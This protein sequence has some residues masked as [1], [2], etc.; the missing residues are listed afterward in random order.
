MAVER[1]IKVPIP[2]GTTGEIEVEIPAEFVHP[3]EPAFK[4][5]F[6]PAAD[7]QAELTR[8][9]ANVTKGLIKRDE[10]IEDPEFLGAI[11]TKKRDELLKIMKIEPGAGAPDIKA[12]R[13]EL[14]V[15]VRKEFVTPLEARVAEQDS[16]IGD[17]KVAGLR[18][19]VALAALELNMEPENQ[20]LVEMFVQ[21]HAAYDPKARRH[22]IK[23]MNGEEGFEYSTDPKRGGNTHMGVAEF[24]A[25]LKKGGEKKTWFRDGTQPGAG[26]QAGDPNAEAM[27]LERFQKL[28]STERTK[29]YQTNAAKY[30]EFMAQI[31]DAG[32][33]KL[34]GVR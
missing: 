21:K 6:T 34:A 13:A 1:K 31:R 25:K 2:A 5:K 8:R 33:A 16:E 32:E 29:F 12:I 26:F 19:E 9:V 20:D 30:R 24:L 15:G 11:A 22:F 18:G 27:T 4:D 28:T 14:E 7:F 17:L 3:E 10:A 23:K